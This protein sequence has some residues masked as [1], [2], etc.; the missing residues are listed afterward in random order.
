M[1]ELS[2]PRITQ[3]FADYADKKK[4]GD[5]NSGLSEPRITQDF[6]DCAEKK[7]SPGIPHKWDFVPF[8]C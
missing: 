4:I 7:F 2:E 6:A 3:D 8:C 1:F 5:W